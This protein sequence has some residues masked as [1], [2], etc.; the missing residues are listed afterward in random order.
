MRAKAL[1][2][3]PNSNYCYATSV[4]GSP[5]LHSHGQ[6][7]RR[8]FDSSLTARLRSPSLS[9]LEGSEGEP[10]AGTDT[11]GCRPLPEKNEGAP[12]PEMASQGYKRVLERPGFAYLLAAQALAVFDDN[13]FKQLLIFFIIGQ[14]FET[15]RRNWLIAL[16]TCL[17]VLP[18]ILFS[19]Y[20]G[21]VADRFSK[22]RVIIALKLV[23]AGL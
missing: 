16:G 22:R 23:E 13:T 4:G 10:L 15:S 20:A 18:Y 12:E 7:V 11:G 2:S 14:G 6:A 8:P 5:D 21:Q 19:S 3:K 1:E 17:Y 9:E